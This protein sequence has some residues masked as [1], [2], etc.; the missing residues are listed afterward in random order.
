MRKPDGTD[1][2]ALHDVMQPLNIILL[3][4]GNVRARIANLKNEDADYLLKKMERIEQ[5]AIRI[6]RIFQENQCL[7]EQG[8]P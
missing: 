7:D 2:P 8:E 5:Q 4:C 3:S 1:M 6:R